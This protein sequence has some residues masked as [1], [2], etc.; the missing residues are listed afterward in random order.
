MSVV[1]FEGKILSNV[2]DMYKTESGGILLN[3]AAEHHR[4][5]SDELLEQALD[6]AKIKKEDIDII[7]LS[8]GPG[9][10]PCLVAGMEFAKKLAEELEI[11]LIP[12]NHLVSH[13]SI[14]LLTTE[15]KDPVFLLVT[16]ANTQVI[17]LTGG[18][19]R[20]LGEALTIALGNA[21]DKFARALDIGFPGGPEIERLAKQ[22]EYVELPYVVKGMDVELSGIVTSAVNK[23]NQGVK[24]EDLCFSLQETM[25]AMLT[26]VT[27]RAVAF[28]D[29]KEV[30]LIGGVAANKRFIEMLNVMCKERNAKLHAVPLEYS[31]DQAAQ[32]AWQGI[33][34]YDD[35]KNKYDNLKLEDIDINPRWRIDQV[36][37]D[38]L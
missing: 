6:E 7:S 2:K 32:I 18:K 26:E 38:Y 30:L 20:I 21:L 8:S 22:G 36:E 31:G 35:N 10:P 4:N 5:I 12:V 17:A 3:E 1:T 24:K 14:G 25:F 19:Y 37:L 23:Y 29:K 34:Q 28:V 11:P 15:A 33:L 9:L 16:G 27:E 13:L